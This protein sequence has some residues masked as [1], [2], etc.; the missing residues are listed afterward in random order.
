MVPLS[1]AVMMLAAAP[2]TLSVREVG[3]LRRAAWSSQAVLDATDPLAAVEEAV[4]VGDLPADDAE[5]IRVALSRDASQV[6]ALA[7]I[8]DERRILRRMQG[9]HVVAWWDPRQ[10]DADGAPYAGPAPEAI[11]AFDA[12]LEEAATSFGVA[13]PSEVP[14]RLDLDADE[15][16][17]HPPSSLRYGI[18]TSHPADRLVA[19]RVVLLSVGESAFLVE[20]LAR[21]WACGDSRGCRI[22]LLDAARL[23]CVTSGHVS[24]LEAAPAR[25][26]RSVDDPAV[27][28]GVL[29]AD[30]LQRLHPPRAAV[31]LLAALAGQGDDTAA[32]A[33]VERAVGE[34]PARLDRAVSRDLRDWAARRRPAPAA[35]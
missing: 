19:A 14:M 13:P 26:L 31:G 16:R 11:A 35:R 24:L 21:L 17:I 33:A 30:H 2:A 12:M 18:V 4:R 32:R 10:R 3:A 29:L 25:V 15:P 7:Q 27:A 1:L 9:R 6:A 22:E 20:A 28:S 5:R 23:R 34:S 8:V